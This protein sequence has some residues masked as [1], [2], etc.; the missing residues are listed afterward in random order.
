[1]SQ[2][3]GDAAGQRS[4]G[5]HS[6]GLGRGRVWSP[7]SR[8]RLPQ[9][10]PDQLQQGRRPFFPP[11]PWPLSQQLKLGERPWGTHVPRLVPPP[12]CPV[13]LARDWPLV[14]AA[15]PL[16]DLSRLPGSAGLPAGPVLRRLCMGG[17]RGSQVSINLSPP[18]GGGKAG[19]W[20]VGLTKSLLCVWNLSMS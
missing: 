1:M 2:W 4:V 6:F 15:L 12:R 18:Q 14:L 10:Q 11:I 16:A 20:W 5:A 17:A 13:I 3:H 7:P 8:L 19:G 9:L